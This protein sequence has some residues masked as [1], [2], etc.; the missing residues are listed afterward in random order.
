MATILHKRKAANPSSSDLTVGELA[1]NT[2]DGGVFTKTSG[3]TLV[4]VTGAG[5]DGGE[6]NQN[7]WQTFAVSGQDDVTADTATDTCTFVAGSNVTI[8]TSASGDSVTFAS[9]DTN[10][11]Y[12]VGDGGLTQNNFTNTLKSKLDGIEASATADQTNA[13]IRA[14]VE[15]ATDSNVF[16]DADHSKLNAIEASAD[17]TDATNVDSAG[18]VM[19]SDLDGK[20]ELLAGDGSGD[21]SALA[22]GSNGQFLKADSSTATGLVWAADNNTTYSVG[23]GGLTQNNF[24]NTLKS[25]LDGIDTGAKDDQTASEIKTLLASSNIDGDHIADDS[26]NSEHYVDGSIDH[27]HLSN[28]CIDGDNIQDDVLNSEHYAAASIDHEH[29]AND[30]VDGDNIADDAIDSE[31]YVN[32][33]IDTVHLADNA[34]TEQKMA[35]DAISTNKIVDDA[36]N[37]DKIANN[38][39]G[40]S[41]IAA[42]AVTG[43]K[44]PDDAIDSEHYTDGSIDTAHIADDQVTY[45]KIQNVSATNRILGRDSSGAGV[46]EEITPANLR[47]MINVENGATADQSAAEIIALIAGETI[48]PGVITTTNLTMDFGSVA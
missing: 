34:C 9:T 48:A 33:S 19:N 11:T 3:G 28:D 27:A 26:I 5:G 18:A 7:A 22:V 21:P 29:L 16:T 40:T 13:E 42:D 10:T 6:N 23:D 1:I 12:S 2:S 47:T 4:E 45:A 44:I 31:H 43:A 37:S 35:N 15:A 32:G 8:T 25:K 39:V 20:G 38:A 14:A 24:T 30:A 41:Q 36:V 46:I 17:V